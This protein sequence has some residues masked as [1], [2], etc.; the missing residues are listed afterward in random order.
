MKHTCKRIDFNRIYSLDAKCYYDLIN[1][2][3]ARWLITILTLIINGS[4]QFSGLP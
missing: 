1:I 4:V 2:L 3:G